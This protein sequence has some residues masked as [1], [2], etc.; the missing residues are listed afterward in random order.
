MSNYWR[1]ACQGHLSNAERS[2][3]EEVLTLIV[4]CF[5]PNGPKTNEW[6]MPFDSSPRSLRRRPDG[7]IS[8]S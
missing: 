2:P 6:F 5:H 4:R 3:L 1:T 8:E 7:R